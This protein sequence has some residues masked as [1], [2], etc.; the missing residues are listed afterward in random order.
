MVTDG[1]FN[2]LRTQGDARPAHI[3]QVIHDQQG[4][5]QADRKRELFLKC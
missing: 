5:V 3:W 2:S 1:E 4:K